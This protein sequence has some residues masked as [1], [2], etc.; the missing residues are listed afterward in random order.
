MIARLPRHGNYREIASET[1][2]YRTQ[3][4][5]LHGWIEITDNYD[6]L[7]EH[8]SCEKNLFT[9]ES[10]ECGDFI[11]TKVAPKREPIPKV[12]EYRYKDS[13]IAIGAECTLSLAMEAIDKFRKNI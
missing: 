1:S 5:E 9:G 12:F 3:Y 8:F 6:W 7:Q 11:I 4:C 13:N 10:L 2:S